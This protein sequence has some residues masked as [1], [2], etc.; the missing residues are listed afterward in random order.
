MWYPCI[1]YRKQITEAP[2][3]SAATF[4]NIKFQCGFLT[5]GVVY[6]TVSK[7]K[8]HLRN[9]HKEA[10]KECIYKGCSFTT[11]N[12]FTLKVMYKDWLLDA[13]QMNSAFEWM[14]MV[15]T[16]FGFLWGKFKVKFLFCM[17]LWKHFLLSNIHFRE[18]V[19]AFRWPPWLLKLFKS[20]MWSW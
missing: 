4:E 9:S 8:T 20:C 6:N 1:S 17:F 19:L 11:S 12:C 5:C 16:I 18:M 10:I 15:F 3:S 7:L 2:E 14:L 13:W